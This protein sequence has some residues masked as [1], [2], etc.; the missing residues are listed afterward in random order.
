M[1]RLLHNRGI[2]VASNQALGMA[3][4]DFVA[5]L[6][7][8]D[9][10]APEAL[11]WVARLLNQHPDL[12]FIY[13]DED[14]MDAEGRRVE[15][16]FK[17]GWSPDLLTSVNYVGHLAVYRRSLLEAL[18]GFR[19]GFDG[20]Q[21]HDLALRVAE[22]TDRIAHIPRPL[23][24]WRK[25]K[26]SAAAS[27]EAKPHAYDAAE[28]ALRSALQRRGVQG[29]VRYERQRGTYRVRRSIVG[30][31]TVTIIVPTRD[32]VD[33]LRRC[34][35]SIRT[36]TYRQ[37][38]LLVVDNGSAEAETL[39]YLASFGGRVLHDA[40]DFN[41]SR[42]VNLGAREARSDF[43]L[44]LNNDTEVISKDWLEAMVEHGQRPEVAAV[45]ARLLYP[46]GRSQHEGVIIGL[47]GGP[48]ENV[49]HEGYFSLGEAVR[50]FSA[51]TAACMLTR[52]T[53]FWELGGFDEQLPVAFNDVDFCLRA[54]EKGY[55]IV[56]TPYALLTHHES[57]SRG[58][59]SPPEDE[60]R[61]MQR[62][63]GLDAYGDP[64][65]NPN[66]DLLRPFRIRV[67]PP[68]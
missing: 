50:N 34:I 60:A 66:L 56:Y 27:P 46:D 23:Y 51:V 17:P 26:G 68:L 59:V 45:G 13:S 3:G 36:C 2:A 15:V 7:H 41:F 18:G 1:T 65:Y 16:F 63:G 35:D 33:L 5:L 44:F 40:G 42:L 52:R 20:S 14:K 8:D 43:I 25:V 61:F 28:R 64:Y 47:A 57:A 29:S 48:A 37:F 22:T 21:D 30:R 11:F 9:V 67:D 39:D 62:W 10:L 58:R 31:P 53:T 12:D 6:D 38:E 54:R 32:R 4:G 19:P 24:S 49:D 55:L